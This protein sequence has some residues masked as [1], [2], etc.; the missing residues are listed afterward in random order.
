[1]LNYHYR[2]NLHITQS[3]TGF[4]VH[5]HHVHG[6]NAFTPYALAFNYKSE[7]AAQ[8]ACDDYIKSLGF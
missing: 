1:M 3:A 4:R 5:S 6:G 7:A 8:A 2:N